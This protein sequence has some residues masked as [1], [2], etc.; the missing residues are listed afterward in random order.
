M[1]VQTRRSLQAVRIHADPAW[2]V[3][4]RA[5]NVGIVFVLLAAIMGCTTTTSRPRHEAT[6][7]V[8]ELNQEAMRHYANAE[9]QKAQRIWGAAL[10]KEPDSPKILYN[11]GLASFARQEYE[12]SADLFT[13][14]LERDHEFTPALI[15]RALAQIQIGH[16]GQASKDLEQ[17]AQLAPRDPLVMFN[18]G[19]L[20]ARQAEYAQAIEHYTAALDI[21]PRMASAWNNR[22]ICYLETGEV[23][24][25]RSDFSRAI[26]L[27]D[28][29]A[30]YSFNRAIA[31][32]RLSR[33]DEAVSDYTRAVNL[34][35]E[36]APAY[37]NRG[38]LRLSLNRKQSG[39]QDLEQ[40]CRLG[41]CEQL[42]LLQDKGI[43]PKRDDRA[44]GEPEDIQDPLT[45]SPNATRLNA[46]TLQHNTRSATEEPPGDS[47]NQTSDL[48]TR[49]EA[50]DQKSSEPLQAEP[51]ADYLD[52]PTRKDFDRSASPKARPQA[53]QN[54]N[55]YQELSQE[56]ATT[57]GPGAHHDTESAGN[58]NGASSSLSPE[59][60]YSRALHTLRK[61]RD[62]TSARKMLQDFI[63]R[64]PESP[65]LP[66]AT[67]WLA[68]T[69]YVQ[70]EYS[71]SISIFDIGAKRFPDHH[72]A[73]ACLLKAGL[74]HLNLKQVPEARDSFQRLISTYPDSRNS[75]IAREKMAVM[76]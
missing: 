47:A 26:S 22:G 55:G 8:R 7:K 18:R 62:Y 42:H 66:N 30:S 51:A 36:M 56:A 74:A 44:S 38:L 73:P 65:N 6:D 45:S 52:E 31:W 76:Q 5:M 10:R 39:C 53:A 29:E 3:L 75:Q 35:P 54:T 41:M 59:E 16:Y 14:A 71:K 64:F 72:K 33:Y 37:Y 1:T 2:P 27:Q 69:Y 32:E 9:F 11:L 20:A 19:V 68:E 48:A 67:Y 13:R 49:K 70:H 25:A 4:V 60:L 57:P 61:E 23:H 21:E 17:A 28:Q 43:C 12:K 58:S 63:T 40:A 46:R 24:Q 34:E 15:N 50:S